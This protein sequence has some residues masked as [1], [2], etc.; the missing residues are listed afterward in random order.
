MEML[1]FDQIIAI[2]V[3]KKSEK[4]THDTEKFL[5]LDRR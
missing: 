4:R 5:R 3:K 1:H 2:E